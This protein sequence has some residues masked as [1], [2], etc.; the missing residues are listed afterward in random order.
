MSKTP[1]EIR[2]ELIKLAKDSLFEGTVSKRDALL[3][4]YHSSLNVYPGESQPKN[5]KPFPE[6]PTFPSSEDIIAEAK[7]LKAFVDNE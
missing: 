7:K 4:E 3:Q 2:L 5:P 1:Y 6:M